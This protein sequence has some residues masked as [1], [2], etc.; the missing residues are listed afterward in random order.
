MTAPTVVQDCILFAHNSKDLTREGSNKQNKHKPTPKR[1]D[2]RAEG[3]ECALNGLK[4]LDK[5][6]KL[7]TFGFYGKY[8][9]DTHSNAL[10][11][12]KFRK[13]NP[14]AHP[15]VKFDIDE[16]ALVSL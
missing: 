11:F 13:T 5:Q 14:I 10:N 8:F 16:C 12:V 4:V 6:Y 15:C 9:R 1:E 7:E 3:Y 2:H